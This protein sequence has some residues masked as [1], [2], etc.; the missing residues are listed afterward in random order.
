MWS[1]QNRQVERLA[2]YKKKNLALRINHT[3]GL[4]LPV[5]WIGWFEA[6][7]DWTHRHLAAGRTWM[8]RMLNLEELSWNL[9]FWII[10]TSWLGALTVP[11][12]SRQTAVKRRLSTRKEQSE[13]ENTAQRGKQIPVRLQKSKHT[14]FSE[15]Q[16]TS[17]LP[18][19]LWI[20]YFIVERQ[21]FSIEICWT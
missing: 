15:N 17:R 11:H 19:L 18:P 10:F 6:W 1:A 7:I 2:C 8:F 16:W 5:C 9:L 14:Y 3:S 13:Q 20:I 4:L 21:P 12:I